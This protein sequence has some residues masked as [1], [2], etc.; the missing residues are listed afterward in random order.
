MFYW[1]QVELNQKC[2]D[3]LLEFL[4]KA[5]QK[6][7]KWSVID[8]LRAMGAVLYE[9]GPMCGKVCIVCTITC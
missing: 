3:E 6:C 2:L 9:A 5:I 1:F 8:H 4:M 7:Q